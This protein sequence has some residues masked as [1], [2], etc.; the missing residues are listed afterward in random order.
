[1]RLAVLGDIHGNLAALEAVLAHAEGRVDG[2]VVIGDVVI[3]APDSA[4]CWERVAALECP[5]VRGNHEGYLAAF[6][7]EGAP[8]ALSSPQFAPVAWAVRRFDDET[9]RSLG[10][11]PL[12]LTLPEAPGVRFVHA[13]L[14]SDRDSVDAYTTEA[15]LAVMFPDLTERYVF[16]GH[17]HVAATR[18]WQERSLYTVGSVGIPLGGQTEAQYAVLEPRAGG[19][20]PTFYNVPYDVEA[21]LKRF[22]D[23]GYIEEA[24]PMASLFYREVATAAHH[25]FPFLLGYERYSEGGKLGLEAAVSKFLDA[26]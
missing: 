23:T 19:W 22:H 14:R 11:L 12:S 1:M 3:G 2:Y 13:S 5:V 26:A 8:A 9:R 24:G 16:R 15:E 7:T 25:F 6:G 18:L 20:H 4:A 10:A 17:N 21:T